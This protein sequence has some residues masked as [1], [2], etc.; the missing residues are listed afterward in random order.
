ML[1][2]LNRLTGKKNFD[3]VEKEGEVCQSQNFGVAY[4]KRGDK[5]PSRFGV[6]VSTKISKDA[7][8]RNRIKRSLREAVRHILF[9]LNPGYDV[10]FLTKPSIMRTPTDVAMKEAQ[11]TLRE[12]GIA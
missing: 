1:P 8:D 4:I 9:E 7:V 12:M 10:I 3:R 2:D 5:N 6:I 11:R